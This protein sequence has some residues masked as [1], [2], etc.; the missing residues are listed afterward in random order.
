MVFISMMLGWLYIE[1][2]VDDRT[3]SMVRNGPVNGST[4]MDNIENS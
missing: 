3:R 2:R 1:N 4:H